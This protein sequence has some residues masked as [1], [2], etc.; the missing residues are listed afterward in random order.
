MANTILEMRDIT[1]KFAGVPALQD[2]SFSVQD[3]EIHAIVGE[4]GAGKSTLMKV[5]SGV[6]PHGSFDGKIFVRGE[7]C[8]FKSIK[9]S[10]KLGIVIIHQELALI[11]Y[12]S[13]A[14]NIFLGNEKA[15]GGVIDWNRT[16]NEAGKLL[17]KV[18]LDE[19]PNTLIGNIGVGKQQ[20]VEIAKALSKEVRVLILDEPTAALNDEESGNLLNLLEEL[21][22]QGITSILI[23]HKLN[24]IEQ[25]AD[26]IT[27]I[28]DG[29][30]IENMTRE[31]GDF[32]EDRIIKSMVGRE[33]TDRWPTRTH[34]IGDEMFKV[35]NWTVHH[36]L[37]EHR[38]VVN[39]VNF[40]IRKGEVIGFAGLMGAGRTE[41]AMSLFG[42]S[43][44]QKHSGKVFKNGKEIRVDTVNHCIDNGLVY[45][46]EDR[47]SYGLVL[48]NDIKNNISLANLGKVSRFQVINPNEEVVE[49]E[50]YRKKLSVRSTG[51][52]QVV[53]SL[54]GG[55]QQKVVLSKWLM[56]EP[57]ILLL[58]EPTR[59]IDV[60]AKYEIYTI[61]NE[62]AA[63]GKAVL[64]ISSEMPELLGMCD[65]I[66]VVN[67]GEIAGC[68][69]RGEASQ[70]S[71]MKTI[72]NHQKKTKSV[73]RSKG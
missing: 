42:K 28:R 40:N 35:E 56:S 3:D 9:D 23:S 60:G 71:I 41:I 31:Q 24:E 61:I 44:G 33:I 58:D 48:I 13:I 34:K 52:E 15:T 66:F 27:V 11:P 17:K 51:L 29:R 59:G 68:L 45:L 12:L 16:V 50:K 62:L 69:D 22:V 54:S 32:H 53:E 64:M 57:D 14:E 43:Y 70:E 39:N 2:V 49:A 38:K 36:P 20:L 19:N 18:G 55:N 21:K 1:K 5:L 67:D 63:E 65:R 73:Q 4:N 30:V 8:S 10:E 72:M 47:K 46:T 37:H 26:Q 6:H 25:V 7:E